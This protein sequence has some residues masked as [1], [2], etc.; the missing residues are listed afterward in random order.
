MF[1][2]RGAVVPVS[3][4][5]AVFDEASA[6]IK[7]HKTLARKAIVTIPAKYKYAV[8]GTPIENKFQDVPNLSENAIPPT[9]FL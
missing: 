4:T 2:I 7:N 9:Y 5:S 8:T 1:W 3:N 6:K